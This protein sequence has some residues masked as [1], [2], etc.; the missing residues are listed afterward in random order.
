M[1]PLGGDRQAPVADSEVS[2]AADWA[3]FVADSADVSL[4]SSPD[5]EYR[6]VSA[7]CTRVLGWTPEELEG[8]REEDLANPDDVPLLLARRAQLQ[9]DRDAVATVSYRFRRRDGS[10]CWVEVSSRLVEPHGTPV[11]VS[12]LRDIT[13]RQRISSVLLRQATT[14][15]LTGVANRTVLLDR[16]RQGLRRLD[17]LPGVLAVLALDLDR[18]KVVNDSLGHA[19]GDEVL[20]KLAERLKGHLRPSDTLARLGGDEFVIVADGLADAQAIGHLV[21]RIMASGRQPFLVAGQSFS[22]T[23]SIGVA[24]TSDSQRDPH[25]L[26][27]EADL[28]LYRAKDNGRDR[29]ELFDEQLRSQ[30][31]ARLA[32]ERLVRRALEEDRLVVH[33]QPV[34]DVRSRKV[35]GAEALVRLHDDERHLLYPDRFLEVA[36]ETGLL[37]S[38]DEHV[39]ADALAQAAR[40]NS[41]PGAGPVDVSVNVT[42]RHVADAGFYRAV[43]ARLDDAGVDPARLQVEV[44]ERLLREASRSAL[45]GLRAL[46]QAGVQ[47][48]LDGFGR[49]DSSLTVLQQLPLDFLKLDRSVVQGLTDDPVLRAVATAAFCVGRSLGL[50]SVAE[51]VQTPEQLEVLQELGCEQAQGF[52]FGAAVSPV[53]LTVLL[54]AGQLPA[55]G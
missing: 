8:Q 11:V 45:S 35:L 12:A 54:G 14:D 37:L 30:G 39:L 28:A 13:D 10:T 9:Q 29:A 25:E 53:E 36:E 24:S 5:G 3:A 50:T 38:I 19:V 22:C 49:G 17:R 18:F 51:G 16:L 20:L 31:L 34:V 23:V 44:S 1:L 47:V 46:R 32:T 40:W 2:V 7:A 48:G 26:L 6:H 33:Y 27:R 21:D 15:P 42:A 4:V 43:L 41:P 55:R 52:L